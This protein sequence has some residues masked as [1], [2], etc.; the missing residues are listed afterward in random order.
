MSTHQQATPYQA[1][2]AQ[3]RR[4]PLTLIIASCSFGM[5]IAD[6]KV[7]RKRPF[8]LLRLAGMRLP[9]LNRVIVAEARYTAAGHDCRQR[10]PGPGSGRRAAAACWRYWGCPALTDRVDNSV[11]LPS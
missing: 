6:G 10:L 4:L 8:A 2:T 1:R 7:E 9:E 11:R 3:Q 5:A